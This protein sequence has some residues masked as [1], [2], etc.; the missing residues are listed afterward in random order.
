[1]TSALLRVPD[2]ALDFDWLAGLI[3]SVDFAYGDTLMDVPLLE[4]ADH[5]VAVYPDANLRVLAQ[6]R[7]WEIMGETT[8]YS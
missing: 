8:S 5:P 4:H 3:S 1:M 6:E 2:P 7:G